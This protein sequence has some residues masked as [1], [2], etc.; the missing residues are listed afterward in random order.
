MGQNLKK[1]MEKKTM[2]KILKKKTYR[3]LQKPWS[4]EPGAWNLKLGAYTGRS[5]DI[6]YKVVFYGHKVI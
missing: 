5:F 1:K 6:S 3:S 4:L 2:K